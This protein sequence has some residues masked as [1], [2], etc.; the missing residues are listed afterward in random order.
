LPLKV[1]VKNFH[2]VKWVRDLEVEVTN[3]SDKPIYF[4]EFF[5]VMRDVKSV[6]GN[7]VG[8]PLRYGRM[9]LVDYTTPLQSDDVGIQPGE[10]YTFKISERHLKGWEINKENRPE[11]K[12]VDLIFVQLNFG[13]GTG[14]QGTAGTPMPRRTSQSSV[15]PSGQGPK[16]RDTCKPRINMQT[17]TSLATALLLLPAAFLPVNF[18]GTKSDFAMSPVKPATQD[19]C[20]PGT[21]CN[22]RKADFYQCVCMQD[23]RTTQSAPCSDPFAQCAILEQI[24]TWCPEFGVGCPEYVLGECCTL[25]A[26]NDGFAASS[27]GG[28]DCRDDRA[29]VNPGMN[30]GEPTATCN[31]FDNG[32]PIDNDCDTVVNC[33]E[34]SCASDPVACPTP[35]PTPCPPSGSCGGTAPTGLYCSS[36]INTCLYPG[37]GCPSGTWPQ[38]SIGCC[39]WSSPVVVDISG[40]GFN[41]TGGAE[42]VEF[43]I[44]ADGVRERVSWTA[45]NSDDAW[46]AL[47]LNGNGAIDNGTELF[48]DRTPQPDPPQGEYRNGFLALAEY[49]KPVNGGNADGWIDSRDAILSSLRLWQ[50]TNH[51]GISEAA[52]LHSLPALGLSSLDLDYKQS[53]RID[54][55]GNQFRY[56]AK[57][58]DLHGA[59]LGRWAWDV[60]LVSGP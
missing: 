44:N 22:Y 54:Q 46:L 38:P 59:Q 18:L 40:N 36:G 48:G 5:V 49:D 15:A 17:P 58:K 57:V 21:S 19:L 23:A 14:F 45:V 24:D 9:A 10:T 37:T 11:P 26:D 7:P 4:L 29:D 52:E 47:D 41:L 25:D 35:T 42:G 6:N 20:C 3:T 13:D 1:K 8:F 60:F 16:S 43:D 31:D 12:R 50:D 2:N 56:R 33:N 55:Y 32:V 28:P 51:N 53:K 30:E 34:P 39:C 27:C